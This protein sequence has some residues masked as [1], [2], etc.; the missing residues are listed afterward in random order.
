MKTAALRAA[1]IGLGPHGFRHLEA[2]R[3]L[4][5]VEIAA[6]CDIRAVQVDAA[7]EKY[8]G[9]RGYCDWDKL[10]REEELDLVSIATNGPTHAA[11]T[12]AAA[13]A[14]VAYVLCEKP[15]ATSVRDAREMIQVCADHST[16]LSISHGRRWVR[17]Y[18][19]L[20]DLIANGTIGKP[21]HFWFTCGGGL[22]AGNGMH[23]MD[24]A[25]ML[26]GADPVSVVGI[27]DQ[28]GTPN[29][30]GAKFRDPGAVA[31][32][33]FS[34]GMRFVIDMYEDLGVSPRIEITGQIGRVLID[35]MEK[36]WEILAR[37]GEDREK[38][39]SQYWLPI[40]PVSFAPGPLDMIQIL[41]DGL[42]ELIGGGEIGCTGA[43]GL[44][45]LEMVIGAHVSHQNGNV[46]VKLPLDENSA[47]M[48]LSLT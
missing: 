33:Q 31:M 25:R 36:R 29:P 9:A 17:S 35:E 23:F 11:I 28:T 27:V 21:A 41:E 46:P 38:A 32:Y 13:K 48:N 42:K 44:A 22:F 12:I 15:M 39:V 45:A 5:G 34:N 1:V 18:Q 14:G 24:L 47:A 20:R 19:D 10:L 43:D 8:P 6:V 30:R 3:R 7:T 4:N 16:R 40:T 26:S 2:Y 37:Q